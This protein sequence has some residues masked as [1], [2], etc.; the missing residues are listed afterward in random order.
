[1][2]ILRQAMVRALAV[3]S[4]LAIASGTSWAQGVT[5]TVTGTVKDAQ[6]GVVPGA[7]VILTSQTRGTVSVP[8]VTN[9]SG[10]F[11]FPNLTADTYTLQIEMSSFRTMKRTGVEVN[12]GSRIALGTLTI[13]VGGTSEVVTVTAETPM[14]QAASGER[15]F[16]IT[17]ESVSNLPLANR[18]YDALLALAG[19]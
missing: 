10:D 17:T 9:Q 8:V 12:P 18:S 4:I 6:G 1:M 19:T 13:D 2:T 15:S 14:V 11:V 5:G 16:A 7:T 3:A